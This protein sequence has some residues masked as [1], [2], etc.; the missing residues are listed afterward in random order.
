[1]IDPNGNL[2]IAADFEGSES[3][4]HYPSI[5]GAYVSARLVVA[6]HFSKR[7]RDS[8]SLVLREIRAECIIILGVW[9]ICACINLS[10]SKTGVRS[11]TYRNTKEQRRIMDFF[12]NVGIAHT[13]LKNKHTSN[14]TG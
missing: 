7:M 10:V 4:D 13:I 8:A 6:D 12:K 9:Q 3:R 14:H 2:G 1:V 11:S 5:E